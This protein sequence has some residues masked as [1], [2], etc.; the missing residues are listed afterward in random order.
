MPH[1]LRVN[2]LGG[3]KIELTVNAELVIDRRRLCSDHDLFHIEDFQHVFD[4]TFNIREV[5]IDEHL[6]S[7]LELLTRLSTTFYDLKGHVIT[8]RIGR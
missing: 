7:C 1:K 6:E 8:L 4:G 5:D 2:R 3:V